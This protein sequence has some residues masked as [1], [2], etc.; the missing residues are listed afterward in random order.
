[1]TFPIS[2]IAPPCCVNTLH[3]FTRYSFSSREASNRLATSSINVLALAEAGTP[4]V[5]TTYSLVSGAIRSLACSALVTLLTFAVTALVSLSEYFCSISF[6]VST[7][8]IK[9]M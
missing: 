5:V 9:S 3:T 8:Q 7:V 4:T 2:F 6:G 1:M